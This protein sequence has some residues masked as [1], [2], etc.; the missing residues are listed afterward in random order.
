[1]R[2]VLIAQYKYIARF[3]IYVSI[4][5]IA[6]VTIFSGFVSKQDVYAAD[7]ANRWANV[8]LPGEGEAGGWALANG[9]DIKHLTSAP[10]GTL[11]A[12]GAGLAYTLLKSVDGGRKWTYTGSVTDAIID[13]AVSPQDPTLVYYASNTKIYRSSNG[14]KSFSPLPPVPGTVAGNIEIASIAV[15]SQGGN[16]I[17]AGTKDVDT[18]EY[19]GVYALEESSIFPVWVDYNAGNYDVYKV[20]F[21]PEYAAYRQVIAVVNDETDTYVI[22]K[23]A[24]SDWNT[25][26]GRVRL[27]NNNSGSSTGAIRSA[28]IAFSQGYTIN[29][30]ISGTP[31][32]VGIDTGSGQG[33]IFSIIC[34]S[35]PAPSTA[36]DLNIRGLNSGTDI[37]SLAAAAQN[38]AVIILAGAADAQTYISADGGA[39][40]SKNRKAPAGT[41]DAYVLF[42]PDF[43]AGRVMYTAT[44]GP[45]SGVSISRDAGSTW[46]QISLIDTTIANLLQIAVSPCY[47]ADKTLF[48]TTFG[49]GPFSAGLWRTS[50]GGF[51][52]ERILCNIECINNIC[53]SRGYGNNS[54]VMFATGENGGKPVL[55]CS[56]DN[57]QSFRV[58]PAS[59][60][61][62]GAPFTFDSLA[63]MDDNTLFVGSHD[64]SRG[65]IYKTANRGLSYSAGTPAGNNPLCSIA[66]SPSYLEDNTILAGNS[67][68][69]VF[70]S[71]DDG[72]SFTQLPSG[73]TSGSLSGSLDVAFDPGF[74]ENG[75]I[76]V[77][78][79][80]GAGFYRFRAG[81]SDEW[82]SIASSLP[83]STKTGGCVITREGAFYGI[84]FKNGGGMERCLDP[85]AA[86]PVFE[87]V[88]R[89]LSASATL[90]NICAAGSRLWAL[91]TNN[92]KLMTYEDT[93]LSP[94]ALKAPVDD[95]SGI[96]VLIDHTVKNISVSWESAEGAESYEWQCAPD[97]DF[98]AL[99]A[100]CSGIIAGGSVKLPPLDPA[101]TYNW[102]VRVKEPALSPWSEERTFTTTLDTQVIELKLESPAAGAAGIPVK[103]VFQWT[104]AVGASSYELLV[105]GDPGFKDPVVIK[106]GDYALQTSAWECDT[107]LEYDTAYY[108]KVRAVSAGTHSPWSSTGVFTTMPPI[109]S[110]ENP[111]KIVP[112]V[113]LLDGRDNLMSLS[114]DR[115]TPVLTPETAAQIL[116]PPV[117]PVTS[118][119]IDTGSLTV[120]PGWLLSLIW[121][122]VGIVM[123][124]LIII[125][126][127]VL[128]IKRF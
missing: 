45:D 11:Y 41:A 65:L 83:P 69:Q 58:R 15:E 119:A 102:R 37:T 51:N 57:G 5:T 90:Q 6:A 30:D 113:R 36:A 80:G 94:V 2:I 46:N 24:D 7:K 35:D 66:L 75:N 25:L 81:E 12:Y 4:I 10:D 33:D 86:H 17:A 1:M 105:A 20:A 59:D 117:A 98:T 128:K 104:A 123:L 42:P 16:I 118:A 28:D 107:S 122:L 34:T 96:G 21:S 50:D 82:I 52:W 110:N 112:E 8:S 60:R 97:G 13:I 116:P 127:V 71:T 124:A 27:D 67:N 31:F 19:G 84:N 100:G 64:D 3:T 78:S 22:N 126:A 114:A 125:L 70:L 29:P 72:E 121:G 91:D 120:I 101:S 40:W 87:T 32:Y 79:Y 62:T 99:A 53:L 48:L 43:P 23:V 109:P 56:D 55:W 95:L 49:N 88:N 44:T 73:T 108:W 106:I 54:R 103:P 68:G 47:E 63:A 61:L 85:R 38:G 18:G 89:G 77:S 26:I 74:K 93:L 9:S 111:D 92:N 115:E 14:G 76:Y 39:S